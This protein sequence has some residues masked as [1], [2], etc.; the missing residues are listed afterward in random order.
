MSK[1]NPSFM[2]LIEKDI[3][4]A[5]TNAEV[6]TET[7][8]VVFKPVFNEEITQ[9]SLN[10]HV[11]FINHQGAIVHAGTS[12]IA[13]EQWPNGNHTNWTGSMDLGNVQI[14]AMHQIRDT[15]DINGKPEFSHGNCD[16][17]FDYKHS[18]DL[19]KWFDSFMEVDEQR[20]K[21]LFEEKS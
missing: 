16:L 14:T 10:K 13:H 9:E 15:Y 4:E 19:T 2:D 17:F 8:T 11:D 6:I 1:L 21:A 5:Q 7:Q 20:C 3:K 12:N 18:E